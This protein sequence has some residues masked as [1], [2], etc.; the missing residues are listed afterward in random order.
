MTAARPGPGGVPGPAARRGIAAAGYPRSAPGRVSSPAGSPA[1][2]RVRSQEAAGQAR[3]RAGAG[4]P[5]G[6]PDLTPRAEPGVDAAGPGW[7]ASRTCPPARDPAPGEG[8]GRS[9]PEA[10]I[11]DPRRSRRPPRAP[12]RGPRPGTPGGRRPGAA[13][14]RGSSCPASP[15]PDP[16]ARGRRA[17]AARARGGLD[18]PAGAE[19]GVV[20]T[21]RTGTAG[22]H[23]PLAIPPP[24]P[25][26]A[27]RTAP[28]H[29]MRC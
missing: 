25:R 5:G 3:H 16:A 10:A 22:G 12:G 8:G 13:G 18:S 21:A 15:R 1:P 24:P 11:R 26:Q 6:P 19:R 4:R 27:N 23:A 20:R 7:Q 2:D 14:T 28:Q 9:A 17:A 29:P